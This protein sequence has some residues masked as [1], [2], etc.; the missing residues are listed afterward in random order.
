MIPP[1]LGFKSAATFVVSWVS[2]PQSRPGS[3][4]TADARAKT[5][6][7]NRSTNVAFF[8]FFTWSFRPSRVHDLEGRVSVTENGEPESGP[9]LAFRSNCHN[10]CADEE[11]SKNECPN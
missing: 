2:G 5:A 1:P 10:T 3:A 6:K 4:F 7:A 8:T 11:H 9:S